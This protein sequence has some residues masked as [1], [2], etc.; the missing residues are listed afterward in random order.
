MTAT[1]VLLRHGRTDWNASARFQGRADPPLD[2]TGVVQATR[3]A[4]ALRDLRP[5]AIVSSDLRRAAQTAARIAAT[6][7]VTVAFDPGLRELDLGS[8]EGLTR[9]DAAAAFPAEYAAWSAGQDV[10]RGGGETAQ[11][12]GERAL[13]VLLPV[14][15]RCRTGLT[16]VVVSH[17]LVLQGALR[18]PVVHLANGQWISLNPIGRDEH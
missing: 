15:E 12:G 6:C 13:G 17:G 18:V 11:E 4:I 7:E 16:T 14:L 3:A 10:R 1:L 9:S 5:D 8:W 2:D